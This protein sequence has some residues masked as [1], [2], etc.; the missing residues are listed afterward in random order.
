MGDNPDRIYHFYGVAHI[1][2]IIN[3]EEHATAAGYA[4]RREV[5]SVLADG[6]LYHLVNCIQKFAVNCSWF[7]ETFGELPNGADESTVKRNARAYTMML[8]G[9]QLFGDKSGSRIHI[10]WL[11]YVARLEDMGGFRPF[12][13]FMDLIG[14]LSMIPTSL[15]PLRLTSTANDGEATCSS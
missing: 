12:V 5:R 1:A 3:E 10:R 8:L 14:A 13:D 15:S 9:T 11:S 7:Q 4:S 2:D 6:S